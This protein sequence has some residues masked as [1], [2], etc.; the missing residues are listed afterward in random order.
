MDKIF[1]E[2]AKN[3]IRT[4]YE[5]FDK[6][7]FLDRLYNYIAET[8]DLAKQQERLERSIE[9]ASGDVRKIKLA[10]ELKQ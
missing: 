4:S 6:E 10:E 3:A 9:R 1:N 8:I 5:M 7:V 2:N